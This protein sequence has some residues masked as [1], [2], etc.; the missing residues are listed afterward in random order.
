MYIPELPINPYH[1]VRDQCWLT[2][3]AMLCVCSVGIGLSGSEGNCYRLLEGGFGF[4]MKE[5]SDWSTYCAFLA[6]TLQFRFRITL[7]A[8]LF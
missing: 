1:S 2:S 6:H 7:H 5:A 4:K 3:Q 8:S